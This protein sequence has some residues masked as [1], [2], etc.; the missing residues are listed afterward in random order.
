MRR[1]DFLK[2][3]LT[4][5]AAG[6]TGLAAPAASAPQTEQEDQILAD[7]PRQGPKPVVRGKKAVCSSSHPYITDTMLQVM[8][9]GGNA[10][11]A[12]V[13][14]AIAQAVVEPHMTN[15]SGTVSMLF[16]EA[17]TGKAYQLNSSGTI[18]PEMPLFR[19]VPV[20]LFG[21][22]GPSSCA[23]IPGF[24][25][26]MKAMHERF[27]SMPWDYLC[28]PGVAAAEEGHVMHSFEYRVLAEEL[29]FNTYFKSGRELFT[30]D[31]FLPAVG[32]RWRNPALAE[33]LRRCAQ[34]GPDYFITGGWA[35]K[36]IKAAN[37]IGWG[38]KLEH[39]T[40][41]PPRWQEPLRFRHRE[42]E[43]LQ[44][45]P[46]EATGLVTAMFLGILPNLDVRAL[47]HYTESAKTLF[48]VAYALRRIGQE[49]ENINDPE[50][51]GVPVEEWLDPDFLARL[52]RII[53]G[54]LPKIDLTKHVQMTTG[55]AAMAA[56]GLPA[57]EKKEPPQSGSCELS[58]V[59]AD[60]NWVQMMNTLQTGG[61]PGMVVEGVPMFGSSASPGCL[62]SFINC[63][64]T[65]GGRLTM[66]IGNT[67]VLRGGAPWLSLGT[68]GIPIVT[69]PQVLA[70]V[71]EFGMDPYEATIAPRMYPM[72][73]GYE[74]AIE[75][76]LPQQVVVDLAKLGATIVPGQEF[77]YH[78]G[79]FQ[80]CWRDPQT[81]LMNACADH[82][83][84]GKAGGF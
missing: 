68:P 6:L 48:Y 78:M 44:L 84:A 47:G 40:A 7:L 8:R 41:I 33:A 55:P 42:H 13:A 24:F 12:G 37:S 64:L 83:R 76:R 58:I 72:G 35:K 11:D 14:G 45:S 30:H 38:I 59:D 18:V 57:P 81:G 27:G 39:M 61:L 5:G 54:S 20:S 31:G 32:E 19:P 66:V 2:C 69:V 77:N 52:A 28:Q 3:S 63:W 65:G 49:L 67:I 60:G 50:I 29:Q 71:I 70:N 79:S 4:A 51:F 75:N 62:G 25:P 21:E 22:G 9:D 73:D 17:K 46:P 23:V 26:G 56:M 43:V 74:I 36:F 53:A 1:R 15:H 80:V 34:E 82:R 16:W 10:V